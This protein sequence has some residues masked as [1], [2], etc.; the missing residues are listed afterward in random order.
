MTENDTKEEITFTKV[1]E[2]ISRWAK[3]VVQTAEHILES[4][5]K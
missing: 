3:I 4:E 2:G 1:I 5:K